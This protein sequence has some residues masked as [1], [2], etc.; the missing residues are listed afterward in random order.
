MHETIFETITVT[1]IQIPF[2][3]ISYNT[4]LGFE[5]LYYLSN[6]NKIFVCYSINEFKISFSCTRTE[7]KISSSTPQKYS[8]I[9]WVFHDEWSFRDVDFIH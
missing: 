8:D 2:E 4:E 9:F 1:R 5:T 7:G 6:K 3:T